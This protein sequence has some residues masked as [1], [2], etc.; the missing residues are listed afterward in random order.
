MSK[1]TKS[2]NNLIVHQQNFGGRH[3]LHLFAPDNYCSQYLQCRPSLLSFIRDIHFTCF[4]SYFYNITKSTQTSSKDFEY[5][6]VRAGNLRALSGL[7]A[8]TGRPSPPAAHFFRRCLLGLVA[9]QLFLIVQKRLLQ[10]VHRVRRL[11]VE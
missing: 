6:R 11:Q 10:Y 3:R 5:F 9:G 7:M 1:K 8:S 4:V 2:S